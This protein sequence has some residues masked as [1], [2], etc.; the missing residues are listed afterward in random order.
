[1]LEEHVGTEAD[2]LSASLQAR[3]TRTAGRRSAGSSPHLQLVQPQAP[4]LHLEQQLR[5]QRATELAQRV[6]VV[7]QPQLE[8]LRC[9]QVE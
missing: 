4:V 8:R 3:Y 2:P 9:Q 5:G 1:M 7:P 6:L